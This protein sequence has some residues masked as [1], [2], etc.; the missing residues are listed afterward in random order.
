MFVSL[1]CLFLFS[2]CGENDPVVASVGDQELTQSEVYALMSYYGHDIKD[3]S[4]YNAFLK[5]WVNEQV[6]VQ[7]LKETNPE[8]YNIDRLRSDSYLSDLSRYEIE[9]VYFQSKLDTI[10]NE[11]EIQTYY[12]K[13][14]EE[15]ILHDYIVKALY[16]KI[17]STVDYKEKKIQ[18]KF[19]LKN[20]KDLKDVNSYAKLYAENYYFNDSSWIYFTELVEDIPLKKYNVDNIVLNRTKTYFTDEEH[21]Y[22]LNIIDYKLK[23]EAPPLDFLHDQIKEIIVNNRLQAMK[24]KDGNALLKELKKKHEIHIKP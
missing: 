11:E 3:D 6:F 21:T 5:E 23:D 18:Y 10:V 8:A 17:P 19:L 15:F 1:F 12:D 9:Q 24:E 22:F 14:K 20:D 13:H 2:S 7:E 4:V 16:F